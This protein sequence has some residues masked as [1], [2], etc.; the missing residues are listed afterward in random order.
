MQ[1]QV[2]K[3]YMKAPDC[4]DHGLPEIK[5]AKVIKGKYIYYPILK[6]HKFN[7]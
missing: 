5:A 4:G 1:D 3:I 6:A 7:Y 2:Q